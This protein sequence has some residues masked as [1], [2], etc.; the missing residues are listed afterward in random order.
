MTQVALLLFIVVPILAFVHYRRRYLTRS[1]SKLSAIG[2]FALV[3]LLPG[4]FYVGLSFAMLGLEEA[5]GTALISEEMARSF[6]LMLGI[7]FLVW[8]VALA[9]FVATVALSRRER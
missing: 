9:A 4:L 2:R 1:I 8:L 5:T 7:A 3:A 6:L